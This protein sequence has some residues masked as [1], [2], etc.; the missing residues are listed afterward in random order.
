M[1]AV[2]LRY[3]NAIF[4]T[5]HPVAR[6]ADL[7]AMI[8]TSRVMMYRTLR[9]LE[10]DGLVKREHGGGIRIEDEAGLARLVEVAAPDG[11][12]P[13]RGNLRSAEE[14]MSGARGRVGATIDGP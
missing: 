12:P 13:D 3:G 4:D 7:A 14:W 5:P 11:A 1:A 9:G 8:S 2:L 10:A 6:R